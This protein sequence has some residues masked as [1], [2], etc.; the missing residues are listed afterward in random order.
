MK[1]KRE[2][3]REDPLHRFDAED[4]VGRSESRGIRLLGECEPGGAASALEPGE[5]AVAGQRRAGTVE[6][7]KD[8]KHCYL[9]FATVGALKDLIE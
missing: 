5:R 6:L 3:D 8:F 7:L 1:I 2:V 9:T 4:G